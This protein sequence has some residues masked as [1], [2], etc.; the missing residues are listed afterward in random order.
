DQSE[1]DGVPIE[2]GQVR[3]MPEPE[4]LQPAF[5]IGLQVVGEDRVHQQRHMAADVVEDVRLL[6]IVKLVAAPEKTSRGEP[7][8]GEM[9][10]ENVVR[11]EARHRDDPPPGGS[12]ENIAEAP[13]IGNAVGRD[14]K[15]AQPFEI[16]ATGAPD[17]QALLSFEQQSPDRVLLFAI[18]LP[19]LL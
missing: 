12:V 10:E 13:E 3:Q 9:G 16:F 19:V 11:D 7:A 5:T 8:A 6:E 17:Q 14:A 1:L 2:P 4:R 18:A 15:P